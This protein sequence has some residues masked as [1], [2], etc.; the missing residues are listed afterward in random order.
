MLEEMTMDEFRR[1]LRKTKTL[2]V[3]FGTIEAHGSHL[4]LHTDTLIIREAVKE[5]ARRVPVFVAPA[6]PYGVCTSTGDHAGTIGITPAT[7]RG[8]VSDIVRDA[9]RKGLRNFILVSGHG[10]SLHVNAMKEAGEKLVTE[11]KGIKLAAFSIYDV[12][13]KEIG[14]LAET[15]NDSHAGE[16][17]T[18]AVLHIAPGLVKGRAKKEY[19]DFPRP[20]IVK[21]KTAHWRGAVWGDPGKARKDKGRRLLEVMVRKIEELVRKAGR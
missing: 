19:P 20:F 12:I 4:P 17:E 13:G 21:E 1:A 8:M 5:A 11:L 18:S 10:G 15:K 6:L 16:M 9:Y 14:E 7:L 2:I 3:P